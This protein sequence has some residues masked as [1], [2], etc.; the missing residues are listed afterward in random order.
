VTNR[1]LAR[2]LGV[3]VE[4]LDA[5]L[6]LQAKVAKVAR[7]GGTLKFAEDQQFITAR[8]S[9]EWA[10]PAPTTWEPPHAAR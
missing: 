1:E 8:L 2:R 4:K 7:E 3:S 6:R 5:H 10:E 9:P